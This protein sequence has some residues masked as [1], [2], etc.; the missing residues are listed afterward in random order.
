MLVPDSERE[1]EREKARYEGGG[2]RCIENLRSLDSAG[3]NRSK[4]CR[5]SIKDDPS[6]FLFPRERGSNYQEGGGGALS[7]DFNPP[8]SFL[9]NPDDAPS[10]PSPPL[11]CICNSNSAHP[12]SPSSSKS[13][14]RKREKISGSG[15]ISKIKRRH[16]SP[17]HAATM[18]WWQPFLFLHFNIPPLL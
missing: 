13:S 9:Q 3:D 12:S 17:H 5:N 15:N 10:L 7:L 11:E 14:G 4:M 16:F 2:G 18:S 1:G 6:L 8:H